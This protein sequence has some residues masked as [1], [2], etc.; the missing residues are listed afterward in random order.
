MCFGGLCLRLCA[1]FF[2]YVGFCFVLFRLSVRN[3]CGWDESGVG[4]RERV[5]RV[6]QKNKS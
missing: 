2:L 5:N 3:R 1:C 4:E 6:L